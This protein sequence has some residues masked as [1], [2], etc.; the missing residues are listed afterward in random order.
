MRVIA[1]GNF[2]TGRR[3]VRPQIEALSRHFESEGIEVV[4]ASFA[5]SK[6]GKALDVA[7]VLALPP[8]GAAGIDAVVAQVLTDLNL[9]VAAM[10]VPWGRVRGV[11]V[12]LL[13]HGGWSR[14]GS[15]EALFRNLGWALAPLFRGAFEVQVAS[16]FLGDVLA[17]H[18][19]PC[20]IVP[21]VLSG[22]WT[23]WRI[24]ERMQ[25]RILWL[26]AF[27]PVYDPHLA[28]DVFREVRRTLPRAAMTMVAE[29]A[30]E[31]E[32]RQRVAREA[33]PDV[34]FR[35][36]L[37]LP[38]LM[39]TVIDHD[40]FLHT[41]LADNQP[42]SL[43]EAFSTG[44]P[45]VT[46]SAGG[47]PYLFRDGEAGFQRPHGDVRGL[48]EAVVRVATE[49]GL[50]RRLSEGALEVARRHRWETLRGP[51]MDLLERAR[52]A[53]RHRPGPSGR[54]STPAPKP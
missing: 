54:S 5:P 14:F 7:R 48:A 4:R 41:N 39:D 35:K 12:I 52:E 21:H 24:R 44:M 43:I 17:R 11:P 46:T 13:Y 23:R 20:S 47:M 28:L 51:W 1:L 9:A 53:R 42:L 2:H 10:A 38:E 37:S 40:L 29:G 18:R 32:I 16:P 27:H 30:M 19:V 15:A 33:I 8:G 6:A 22:E 3:E 45:A 49:E 25:P 50:S 34:T 31:E 26:R 36:G